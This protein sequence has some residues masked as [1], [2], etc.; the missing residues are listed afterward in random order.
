MKPT[1]EGN[2]RGKK[3]NRIKLFNATNNKHQKWTKGKWLTATLKYHYYFITT[4]NTWHRNACHELIWCLF[5]LF[6][7]S[8]CRCHLYFDGITTASSHFVII[9][10]PDT[11]QLCGLRSGLMKVRWKRRK[12]EGNTW[13][14]KIGLILV[15]VVVV[16]T[17]NDITKYM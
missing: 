15:V 17:S 11:A 16:V 5:L 10:I 6:C 4:A 7:C 13:N 1:A 3:E 14:V 9:I 8:Y 12:T 2:W